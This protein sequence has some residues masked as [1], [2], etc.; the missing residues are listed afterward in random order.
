MLWKDNSFIGSDELKANTMCLTFGQ[1]IV[2][3]SC[4]ADL[5]Q[6]YPEFTTTLH[7][8]Y[9][10]SD[11]IPRIFLCAANKQ[12]SLVMTEQVSNH[13][14]SRPFSRI[15]GIVRIQVQPLIQALFANFKK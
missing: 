6:K 3:L 14:Q 13:L 11:L 8:V 7:H 4:V 1:P 2:K 9:L 15:F 12:I 10:K 5:V